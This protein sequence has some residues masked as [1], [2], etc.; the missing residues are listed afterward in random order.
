MCMKTTSNVYEDPV[1][2][3][4]KTNSIFGGSKYTD[5]EKQNHVQKGIKC[6]TSAEE[7]IEDNIHMRK[8]I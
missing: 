8:T 5:T 4:R 3:R 2:L 7:E 6:K 1:T